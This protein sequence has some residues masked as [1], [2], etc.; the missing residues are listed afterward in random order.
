MKFRFRRPCEE[1]GSSHHRR[2]P[3]SGSAFAQALLLVTLLVI[4]SPDVCSQTTSGIFGTVTDQQGLHIAGVEVVTRD[5][6][7]GIE[8][9]TLTDSDGNFAAL[10]LQPGT[11]TITATHYGFKIQ[12]YEHLELSVNRQIRLEIALVLGSLRQGVTVGANPPLLETETSSSGSTILPRQVESMPLNGRNYLDLLQLVPGVTINRNFPEG[13]DGSA[14]ILGERANNAYILV[15]GMPNRDEVDGGPGDQF[16]QDSILEFQVL[17]SGY[18]AEFGRGSGGVVNVAT[19]S[20]T[21]DWHGSASLY[22]RNSLLDMSDVAHTAAPFLLRW[23]TS[24]TIGGPLVKERAFFFGAVERIREARQSNFQFPADF[25]T[26]LRLQEESIN[27]HGETYETRAFGR[28]DEVLGR[29][30]LTQEVNLTNAHLTDDGDQPSLRMDHDRRRLMFGARDTVMWGEA[31]K[32]YLLSGYFQH[33]GEPSVTRPSHLDLGVPSVFVNLFT[34]S[35]IGALFGDATQEFVGPGITPLA[36]QEDYYS[37]GLSLAKPFAH[38]TLKF[39]WDF[40]QTVVNGTESANIFDVLF[41]TVD[42]FARYGLVSSGVHVTF[43]Q[44]GAS[45]DLNRIRLR[46]AYNGLYFQDD[47]K[48]RKDATLN[49]GMRWDH[50]AE[51]PNSLNFSPRLG[52]SW[53]VTPKMVLSAS[54]GIFYDHFRIG[55]AR[56]I[57]AFGGAAVSVFQD[58]SFPRLFYGDPTA[59]PLL[60]GLCLSNDLT[61]SQIVAAGATCPADPSLQFF[62]IDHLNGTV[63]RGHT[64]LPPN[65]IITQGNVSA[66]TGL[67]PKQFLN[68]ASTAVDQPPGFFYWG[69]SGNLATA[70]VGK[71][72]YVPPLAVDSRF[73]TPYS[74]TFH[75]GAQHELNRELA[76]YADYFHKDIRNILGVRLTNLAF[77]ARMPGF[78]GETIPG[79][80]DQ[81]IN[82]YGPWFSGNYNA[83]IVG[84]RK[85]AAGRLMF[86]VNYSFAHATDNLLSPSLNSSVQTGAGIRLTA[87]GST[88]DS[89]VGIPPVVT[90]PVT[91]QTNAKG[92]FIASNG[93]PV[94]QAGK[95]YYGPNLDRGPSDLTYTHT[96]SANCIIQLPKQFQISS[97]FRAQSGFHYSRTFT[98]DAPDVDGDGIPAANDFTVGRNHFVAPPFVSLDARLAKS[99]TFGDH[100]KLQTLIEF[101]NVFNRPNPS[102]ILTQAEGPVRFGT[103]TQVLTGREGQVGVKLEF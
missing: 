78:T 46:N 101:F 19:K 22:H 79:T 12:V 99:F 65:A 60:G 76:A 93:N 54:W 6:A 50:D 102:Q 20:G 91:G 48:V 94:P 66:L 70:F 58:I 64:P 40:Q 100:V 13:D 15:D 42:D 11:Y 7:S 53:S 31:G 61:D 27:K 55:V 81:P 82:T 49:L 39:G 75:L 5:D 29:N 16:D 103:V 10:G 97:I 88:T 72:S 69:L 23:D 3:S 67:T 85:Q 77:E 30:R 87:F 95:F 37:L 89:Y 96:L 43:T 21:N 47:W 17:T 68:A 92:P 8:R 44:E 33:R 35:G 2:R 80:G 26:T 18:K 90:D 73:R 1:R 56:D 98:T 83:L 51:F 36:L 84:A 25:P 32:P 45:A 74:R 52:V 86:D 34:P 59:A 14:P 63:A 9:R 4:L 62:G 41:A 71:R 28:L 38:H 57:P 24:A